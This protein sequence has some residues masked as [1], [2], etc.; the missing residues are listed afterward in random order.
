MSAIA[1]AKVRPFEKFFG[2]LSAIA[3]KVAARVAW[4]SFCEFSRSLSAIAEKVPDFWVSSGFVK[5]VDG[6]LECR[7]NVWRGVVVIVWGG[8]GKSDKSDK[9]DR[10]DRLDKS[11]E[12]DGM[13]EI[14]K[15]G[16]NLDGV[17][18]FM[19]DGVAWG[20]AVSLPVWERNAFFFNAKTVRRRAQRRMISVGTR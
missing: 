16:G 19:G 8:M 11:D 9:S 5:V 2:S 7:T 1:G 17:L 14:D 10:S 12:M 18:A 15:L 6:S 13:D 3:E 4:S 20:G